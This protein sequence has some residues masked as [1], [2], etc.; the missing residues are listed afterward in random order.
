MDLKDNAAPICTKSRTDRADP[1]RL[2]L[3]T[4]KDDPSL[5]KSSTDMEEPM[6]EKLRKAI[7]EPT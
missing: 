6:R 4:A 1:K 2:Q 7:D 3:L 5:R